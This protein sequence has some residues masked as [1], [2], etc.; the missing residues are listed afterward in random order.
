[1]PRRTA[2]VSLLVCAS[3]SL[4]IGARALAAPV[5]LASGVT[6]EVDP[7]TPLTGLWTSEWATDGA[8]ESWAGVNASTTVSGGLLS[9]VTATT[10]GRV[11]RTSIASGPD[12][13]LGFNDFLELRLQV[14]AGYAGVVQIYYGTTLTAGFAATRQIDIPASLIPKDGAFHTYRLNL[15]LEVYWRGTLRDLRI[16]PVD[17]AGTSGMSFALDYVR[18]GDEPS[19]PVYQPRY[20]TEC[21]A[22]GGV[23]PG[24]TAFGPGQTVYSLE[25]KRFRILWNDAIIAHA[26]W[27][28][29]MARNTLRN[30]E[31]CWQVYVAKMGYREPA[32]ATG[33]GTTG[34]R[35]KLNITTWHSG[36]WA[37]GDGSHA[38]LNI[39]PDGLRENPPSGVI[40]HELMH[41]F[42]FH[43]TSGNVPGAWWEGHANYGRERYNQ[44]YRLLYA[45]NQRSGIDPTYLRC[46]HQVIA[47][48]RDYYLSWPLFMYLDENPDALPDLGEGTNVKLWQQTASGQ[49]PLTLLENLTPTTSLKD[50]V[51]YFARRGATYNYAFKTDIQA[52]LAAFGAP[53]DNAA[54][55]R[56]QFT[57]LVRRADDPSWWRVPYEMAPMQGAYAIH[58]LVPSTTGTAGRVVTVN[59]HGLPDAARGADWRASFIVISDSGAE[60]YGTLWGA[61]ENSVTLAATE[62]KLHLSVAA[63]PSTFYNPDFDEAVAPYRSH[64]SKTRFPYELQVTGAVPR[65][66]DNINTTT[67]LVQHANGGGWKASTAT[68][69]STV[70]LAPGARV[71]NT[72]NISGNVRLEDYALVTGSPVISGNATLSGRAWVRGGTINGFAKIRDWALVEGGTITGN[73]RVLEHANIK[74]GTLQD[75][76]TAKGAAASSTGVLSG[77]AVIEG[78]YGDFFSGRDVA[79]SVAFGHVPYVGVPDSHLRALPAGLYAAYD[80]AAAHDSRVFDQYGATDAFTLGSPAWISADAKRKGF[81]GFDGAT[82]AVALD[83]SV[84]DLREFTFT[85]WVKPLGGA[86]NQP[87]LWLGATSTRRLY[88]TP[89][90]GAG[91]ARFSIV[92]GGAEQTLLASAPLALGVWSHLAVT[93]NGA[94]GA[95]YVNGALAAGGAVTIRPDQLLAANTGTSP[96][97]N[98]LARSEGALLPFFRGALDD[99]RFHGAALSAADIAAMQPAATLADAGTLHVD[100]RATDA[101][102]GA[103]TWTNVAVG[104][105]LGN[106]ARTGTPTKTTVAGVPGVLFS[107]STQAYASAAN[108]P[109]DLDGASDRSIEVWAYNPSLADEETMVSW[110]YRGGAPDGSDL[111]FNFASNSVWG[112]VTHWGGGY[113]TGWGS[114]PPSAGAWH[115]LVYTYDGATTVRVYIDGVLANTRTLAGPLATFASQPINLACQRDSAGGTRSKYY[116]GYLNRVR[117]HGGV[118]SAA[119]VAGN[120][121]LGPDGAPANTTPALAALS[122]LVLDYGTTTVAVPLTLS[123]ADTAIGA[124]ALTAA[125]TNTALLPAANITFSGTGAS[126][127][128][129]LASAISS[130]TSTVTITVSDGATTSSR[131]FTLT[132][133][134][135]AETWRRQNFG[136]TLDSGPA[137]DAADPDGDGV[138]NLLER[139]LGGNPNAA[140]PQLLPVIDPDAP[141]LSLVYPKSKAASDLQFTV[142]ESPDLSVGA[143]VAAVGASTVLADNGSVQ[144]IRFTAPL[145]AAP[146]KFLRLQVALP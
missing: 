28:S 124:L 94:T 123:D 40:P 126:R 31:E 133:L 82:Q 70:Y 19:A 129:T 73:A 61:G 22:A 86:A 7:A 136:A 42:Q 66:R 111:G 130:G 46:A 10:D 108:T 75:L 131:S 81:L 115:H 109:A 17:G 102:A 68:V 128:A 118:L 110:A 52:A 139:A 112:A 84:A 18:V 45:S 65:Q 100:L 137:A 69:A 71:F 3:L 132:L 55:Q 54:T 92:N 106:F 91:H 12:L 53:L 14:P 78:D 13:D 105:A 88:V 127:T 63:T 140:D 29:T 32:W 74:G 144:T 30:A 116:S 38:R 39:T 33:A 5:A 60:R 62:N 76:A 35:Y 103:A 34:T 117:V 27:T 59:L 77:N 96:Q 8:L 143:W 99:V 51:G 2:L 15:G 93:L 134:T 98:Y 37:G 36:Y 142:Q 138:T 9:G 47:H 79:N 24:G 44:H 85:A 120:Y 146:R 48:G 21:P 20:T 80:F 57:D 4:W 72:A 104:S 119:Q 135:Q 95:L 16:D 114:V 11:E 41:C 122:D 64:P 89:D 25:S 97:H 26:S 50:I 6:V 101:S 145:A 23:T 83:R 125:S 56:W 107:G 43:N 121:S 49:Y 1:M 141:L 58:E 113:D 67:G 87:V 90:D